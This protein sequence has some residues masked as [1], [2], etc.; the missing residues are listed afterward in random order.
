MRVIISENDRRLKQYLRDHGEIDYIYF[1][2]KQ[3]EIT[4]LLDRCSGKEILMGDHREE[5]FKDEF[6]KS[7]LDLI[8]KL[9][10]KYDSIY[11]WITFTSSKNK[12]VSQLFS[13]LLYFYSIITI[14]KE[15][16]EKDIL[17]INP[18]KSIINNQILF[19]EFHRD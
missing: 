19:E 9:G 1:G 18:P 10:A 16:H 3:E 7:Y 12:F 17:I 8:G 14:L 2:D 15:G 5:L 4:C 6:V 13:N 11:W